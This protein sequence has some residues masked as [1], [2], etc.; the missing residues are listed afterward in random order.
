MPTPLSSTPPKVSPGLVIGRGRSEVVSPGFT[1]GR[2]RASLSGI[3]PSHAISPC[4][5]SPP[6]VDRGDGGSVLRYPRAKLLDIYRVCSAS[7]TSNNYPD[8]FNEVPQLTQWDPFEPLA[9]SAPDKD[10]EIV[11]EGILKGSVLSSGAAHSNPKDQG[12]NRA[13]DNNNWNRARGR[14]GSKEDGMSEVT[15]ED[16]L[17][18]IN[19]VSGH[20]SRSL[21]AKYAEGIK[22]G[23]NLNMASSINVEGIKKPDSISILSCGRYASSDSL[24]TSI[25][26]ETALTS[27][28][29]LHA[30]HESSHDVAGGNY[31]GKSEVLEKLNNMFLTKK[32]EVGSSSLS[33]DKKRGL[34]SQVAPEE[35]SLYYIDPQGEV[36]GPFPGVDIIDWFKAGFF[37]TDLLVR[38][39]DSPEG[40]PFLQLS[41]VMPHLQ[42]PSQ[43]LSGID[44]CKGVLDFQKCNDKVPKEVF[45][46]TFVQ[47]L[48]PDHPSLQ[49]VLGRSMSPG[50]VRNFPIEDGHLSIGGNFDGRRDLAGKLLGWDRASAVMKRTLSEGK[51]E[52]QHA[53]SEDLESLL[54][55]HWSERGKVLP[56]IT[57]LALQ[58]SKNSSNRGNLLH[59]VPDALLPAVS[60]AHLERSW[61]DIPLGQETLP[62]RLPIEGLESFPMNQLHQ[63]EHRIQQQLEQGL[64][65][66]QLLQH[67][68]QQLAEQLLN[69]GHAHDINLHALQQLTSPQLSL[70]HL[71]HQ[72]SYP[73]PLPEPTFDQLLRLQ[74]QHHDTSHVYLDQ[75]LR[76]L[77]PIPGAEHLHG[78]PLLTEHLRKL[79]EASL[80]D[81]QA[82]QQFE[83]F[84]Q[85]YSHELLQRQQEHVAVQHALLMQ[86]Q[87]SNPPEP[88]APGAWEFD[89]VSQLLSSQISSPMHVQE[90][91]H[92]Q[93]LQRQAA[94]PSMQPSGASGAPDS[95]LQRSKSEL[96]KLT[97]LEMQ[98]SLTSLLEGTSSLPADKLAQ[99]Q[100]EIAK[101]EA[102]MTQGVFE[103]HAQNYQ[104]LNSQPDS[105]G[106]A[107]AVRGWV[108][109]NELDKRI[110]EMLIK[111]GYNPSIF[112]QLSGKNELLVSS[113]QKDS[114]PLRN[115][116]NAKTKLISDN[117]EESSED[118][119]K[120]SNHSEELADQPKT[121]ELSR[122]LNCHSSFSG[123]GVNSPSRLFH[124]HQALAEKKHWDMDWS[125]AEEHPGR[126]L[127]R[128]ELNNVHADAS[129]NVPGAIGEGR[130]ARPTV[131]NDGNDHADF[132]NIREGDLQQTKD[133]SVSSRLSMWSVDPK[134]ANVR[135]PVKELEGV[136]QMIKDELE[137]FPTSIHQETQGKMVGLP[138]TGL[139]TGNTASSWQRSPSPSLPPIP[140]APQHG[141]VKQ[142]SIP[143]DDE[144]LWDQS[145]TE[146]ARQS[147][148]ERLTSWRE[149]FGKR[150]NPSG[151]AHIPDVPRLP[152]LP[153]MPMEEAVKGLQGP[154][155]AGD[156]AALKGQSSLT[157]AD[158]KD[159][160][161]WCEQQI[162]LRKGLHEASE[163]TEAGSAFD[164][165]EADFLPQQETVASEGASDMGVTEIEEDFTGRDNENLSLVD[166]N[167]PE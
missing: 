49:S 11:L 5:G 46:S 37:G 75:I 57:G 118:A 144:F 8:G 107:T 7:F 135:N 111:G 81:L 104:I 129:S 88:C 113:W 76:Q 89:E 52:L 70:R 154:K 65:F 160:R 156:F 9:F 90:Y 12:S 66:P 153:S 134:H 163:T 14:S 152:R 45:S 17:A 98:K 96:H 155:P 86:Q 64:P 40:T 16:T 124:E 29:I 69:P 128:K 78:S 131:H 13:R 56:E 136:S 58:S 63:M 72:Q 59:G 50:M 26:R 109:S 39:A 38:T 108:S 132:K 22:V 165:L 145:N 116:S 95:Q 79:E 148:A 141:M 21:S 82:A 162:N 139:H 60:S 114:L 123:Q 158:A 164:A 143:G 142:S 93:Q 83:Q 42:K 19:L 119:L 115:D 92:Q 110:N 20:D 15:R 147:S 10:E 35:L 3:S 167:S 94:F 159:F 151:G 101:F 121:E 51:G 146:S 54:A 30:G 68:Q 71:Q 84:F 28:S 61:S 62:H 117:H 24:G 25:T 125:N 140:T 23:T 150:L 34:N 166:P 67:Q 77:P 120:D 55:Q 41:K 157:L 138:A 27:K 106:E 126:W 91:F 73:G 102:E 2:G 127:S 87:L 18:G 105:S 133:D 4:I 48:L 161:D 122:I 100:S 149:S 36:Q 85:R 130:A 31:N 1:V 112:E 137:R 97:E 74:Q 6:G 80:T 33:A 44:S 47:Q 32:H 53:R 99:L 43:V 103:L